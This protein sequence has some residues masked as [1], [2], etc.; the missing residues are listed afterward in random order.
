MRP[1]PLPEVDVVDLREELKSGNRSIF[2]R[3]LSR[4]IRA[5]LDEFGKLLDHVVIHL[6]GKPERRAEGGADAG[7]QDAVL[8]ADG[9][10]HGRRLP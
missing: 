1:G 4:A 5:A 2:S 8:G 6:V 7:A 10:A 9:A 3:E